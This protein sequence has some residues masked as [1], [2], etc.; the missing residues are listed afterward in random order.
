MIIFALLTGGDLSKIDTLVGG[1][2]LNW[3]LK[4]ASRN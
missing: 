3:P 1:K 4:L 2:S